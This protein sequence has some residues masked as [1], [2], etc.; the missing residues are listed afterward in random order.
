MSFGQMAG[1][2]SQRWKFGSIR[3]HRSGVTSFNLTGILNDMALADR[4]IQVSRITGTFSVLERHTGI[5]EVRP[6][7]PASGI[8]LLLMASRETAWAAEPYTASPSLSFEQALR[9]QYGAINEYSY[10]VI[11]DARL[12]EVPLFTDLSRQVNRYQD[13]ISYTPGQ[14]ILE[15][16]H[17]SEEDDSI[18]QLWTIVG[19][20][21]SLDSPYYEWSVDWTLSYQET[22]RNSLADW[23]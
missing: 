9:E 21:P 22:Q 11:A 15:F 14:K 3:M 17:S 13:E 8:K 18:P 12:V 6:V 19:V 2:L 1:P 20:N 7:C 23:G 4:E 5:G 10:E 16:F